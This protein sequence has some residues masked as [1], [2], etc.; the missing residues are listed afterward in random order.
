[1]GYLISV[2]RAAA[3]ARRRHTE[4]ELIGEGDEAHRALWDEHNAIGNFTTCAMG[5]IAVGQRPRSLP[6][7]VWRAGMVSAASPRRH[8]PGHLCSGGTDRPGRC[9]MPLSAISL[10]ERVSLHGGGG[11]GDGVVENDLLSRPLPTP[12]TC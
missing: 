11:T 3:M 1:M 5:A 7:R 2:I 12:T 6:C 9:T 4:G 10:A 8:W